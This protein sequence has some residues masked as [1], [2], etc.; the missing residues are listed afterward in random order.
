MQSALK[1]NTTQ[2]II[3]AIETSVVDA[4]KQILGTTPVLT[5]DKKQ[6]L[7]T[8]KDAVVGIIQL[9]SENTPN[10]LC[11][12]FK[13]EDILKIAEIIYG[14]KFPIVDKSVESTICELCN[15]A[16]GLFKTKMNQK[17]YHYKMALPC[18]SDE[19]TDKSLNLKVDT[20]YTNIVTINDISF[21]AILVFSKN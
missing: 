10:F 5:E 20:T 9:S 13:N 19:L 12:S 18:I 1:L 6:Y 11:L 16:Y 4:F 2:D 8:E 17:G 21:K 3:D 14:Q 15:M 7:T